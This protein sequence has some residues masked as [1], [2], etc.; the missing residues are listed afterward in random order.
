M[1]ASAAIIR[2]APEHAASI[3]E[4]E[5]QCFSAPWSGT[6]YAAALQ[7]KNFLA[8]GLFDGNA[9]LGYI[10]LYHMADEME[11]LNIAV[12]AG[13]RRRGHGRRLLCLILR[14]ARK[15]GIRKVFLE[16]R[17]DNEPAIRLYTGCGFHYA[18]MRRRYYADSGADAHCYVYCPDKKSL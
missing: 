7:Q 14:L 9:L 8:F 11:I 18:G 17:S 16:V 12:R 13:E 5:R 1:P 4:L 15:M 6:Q 3:H 2:L 10:S